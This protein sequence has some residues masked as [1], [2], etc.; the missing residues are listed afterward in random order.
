MLLLTQETW[1]YAIL[2]SVHSSITGVLTFQKYH[3]GPPYPYLK[4]R[5]I[6]RPLHE[7]KHQVPGSQFLTPSIGDS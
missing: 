3:V 2:A 6:R 5:G 7:A 4:D 1:L